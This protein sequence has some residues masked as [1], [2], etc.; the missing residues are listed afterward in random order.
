[1]ENFYKN[2]RILITGHTG[3]KGSW[4]SKV[5][6]NKGASVFGFS[7]PIQ[8]NDE[9]LFLLSNNNKFMT[10][11]FG[12]IRD[13]KALLTIFETIQPEIVFHLAAQPL[14]RESYLDPQKTFETNINGTINILECIRL[15]N[16]VK[17]F[18]NITTDKVYENKEWYW[19]YREIDN[20]NGFD[21]YSNSKSCSDL[22]TQSYINSLFLNRNVSI[23]IVRAGNVI[24]GGDFSNDRIIPDCVRAAISNK[25]IYV[26]NPNSIRPYQHVLEPIFV[27]VLIAQKQFNDK[28]FSGIYNIGPNEEDCYTTEKLVQL[29]VKSWGQSLQWETSKNKGPHEANFLKLDCSKLKSKF[30]WKPTWNLEKSMENTVEWYKLWNSKHSITHLMDEQIESFLSFKAGLFL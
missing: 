2:K 29:F 14:V 8:N 9:N 12:D 15:T 18:V 28:F 27:Y 23:S 22:I 1:M 20:L 4:L 26:R 24:G 5:L 7:L 3:F 21:P 11:F 17:S 16:S 25:K 30:D 19:G 10:S 6:I 13:F